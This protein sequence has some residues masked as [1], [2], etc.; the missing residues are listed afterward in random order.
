ME[1]LCDQRKAYQRLVD[2]TWNCQVIFR[3]LVTL[4][5]IILISMVSIIKWSAFLFFV[6]LGSRVYAQDIELLVL[7]TTQDG[8]SP[9]ISCFKKCCTNLFENPDPER[10]VVS[11]AV[12]DRFKGQKYLFEATPDLPEQLEYLA[13][14]DPQI[15]DFLPSGIFLTHAH[16][17]HYT[18][19]MYF[20]REAMGA[21]GVPVYGLS[22]MMTYIENNGPWDQLVGLGNIKPVSLH[23]GEPFRLSSHLSVLPI[24]VPH[25]D[26]YSET[27]GYKIQGPS[28][29]ALFI[30]DID[31]WSKWEKNILEEIQKVDYALID[32][33][34]YDAAEI[35][36]RDIKEIPHPFVV[37]SMEHFQGLSKKDKNKVIFIHLNH[38]NPLLD[39]TSEATLFVEKQGFRIARR[40]MTLKL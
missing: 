32:A 30:P 22:S 40:G 17:G 12:I 27:A 8:G 28:A 34:F 37:E 13:K 6:L 38:T 20:G 9:H 11:L 4:K 21:Q 31:K 1:S 16:I 5:Q 3:K 15:T 36:Y 25:R 14:Y 18:G 26:E 10:R 23:E 29:T 24:R 19:L 33:T 7:G 2:F 39:P 35:N